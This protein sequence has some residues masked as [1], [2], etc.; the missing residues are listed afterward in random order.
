MIEK[1]II[2]GNDGTGKTTRLVQLKRMFPNIKYEDRGIFSKMTLVDELFNRTGN[3]DEIQKKFHEDVQKDSST[4]YIICR[5]S[6][7]VCQKRILERGDSIEEEFHTL[8]DLN[9][10][11]SRFDILVDIVK[12]LPNVMVVETTK[13]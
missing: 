9:K 3:Y 10:Y 7:E 13:C 12:D 6:S 11:N 4:L 2:D 5:A 1:I 8:D